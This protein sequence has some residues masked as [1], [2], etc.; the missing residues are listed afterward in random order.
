LNLSSTFRPVLTVESVGVSFAARTS[1]AM[2]WPPNGRYRANRRIKARRLRL[3]RALLVT[4]LA[5]LLTAFVTV[6]LCLAA[7][8]E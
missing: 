4:V 1:Q 7:F 2:A 8:F 3:P 5:Q 6:N